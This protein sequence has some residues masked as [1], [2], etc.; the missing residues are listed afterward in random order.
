MYIDANNLYGG[1]MSNFLPDGT[2]NWLNE[3]ELNNINKEFILNLQDEDVLGYEFEVD[4]HISEHLH[5]YFND[6]PPCPETM[7][8]KQEWL[9]PLQNELLL[10][11]DKN[12]VGNSMMKCKKLVPTLFDK[13]KYKIHY[14]ALKLYLQLGVELVKVHRA[15][16]FTQSPFIKDFVQKNTDRRAR[17]KN[18]FDKNLYKLMNN[19]VYGKTLESN[20]KHVD[21]KILNSK[22]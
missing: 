18:D 15:V 11:F 19:S 2:F 5:D 16:S 22:K 14:R 8:I 10:K 3:Q 7:A 20:R 4:L 17:S 1:A 9:S 21:C 12:N 13:I 6:L